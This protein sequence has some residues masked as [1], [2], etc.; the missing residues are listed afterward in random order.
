MQAVKAVLQ[1][2]QT[3]FDYL[4]N[5]FERASQSAEPAKND[6]A[7]KRQALFAYVRDLERRSALSTAGEQQGEQ[8]GDS[9][10]LAG[11]QDNLG[12][13]AFVAAMA[14]LRELATGR[15]EW[16]VQDPVEKCYCM[17]FDRKSSID[18]ERDAR[19]WLADHARRFPDS[20]HAKYEVA[21]VRVFTE[22]ERAALAVAAI[23]SEKEQSHG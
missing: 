11:A 21:E 6:Y 8:H 14:H 18:P 12:S 15:V 9:S 7:A 1:L 16:R 2:A 19:E 17:Y 3:Q 4:L 20:A 23:A 5:A 22:L 10:A 13:P